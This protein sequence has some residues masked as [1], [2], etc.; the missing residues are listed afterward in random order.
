MSLNLNKLKYTLKEFEDIYKELR[1]F[2]EGLSN[3]NIDVIDYYIKFYIRLKGFIH[4]WE[5]VENSCNMN[6][7]LGNTTFQLVKIKSIL[8][9]NKK[10]E[11]SP[12]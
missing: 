2:L 11:L 6:S 3:R 9:N 5:M 12:K 8:F 7:Q 10:H 4:L 1:I